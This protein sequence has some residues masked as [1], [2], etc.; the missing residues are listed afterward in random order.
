MSYCVN[1]GVELDATASV[2]PLCQT[3]VCN[4]RCPVNR[5]APL[6]FPGNRQE[7]A[8]VSRKELALVLTTL[9]A[10]ASASCGVMNLFF[11]F[12]PV[13]WSAYVTGAL[14]MVWVWGILPLFMPKLAPY[15]RFV[16]DLLATAA[17]VAIIAATVNGW[18][19]YVQLALPIIAL[20]GIIFGG[21]GIF[22]WNKHS[23]LSGS[24]A[25]IGC[26]AVFLL[27][28]ELLLDLWIH[29]AYQP[30][31]SVVTCGVCVSLMLPLLVIRWRPALREE[32]RK[33]FHL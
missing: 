16:A 8:P 7:V 1:C 29:E 27:L 26:C 24:I 4:P 22:I 13:A 18:Q 2:C 11:F 14:A 5:E 9:M 32:V 28:L 31:W 17:Y 30:G 6:P 3:P 19:W 15:K 20:A 23:L 12:P 21:Y 33:R 10:A 25:F